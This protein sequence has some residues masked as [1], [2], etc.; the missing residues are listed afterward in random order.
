M[1]ALMH[2]ITPLWASEIEPYPIRVAQFEGQDEYHPVDAQWCRGGGKSTM[3]CCGFDAY[4]QAST[5]SVSKSLTNKATDSD[6]T[7]VVAVESYGF[8]PAERRQVGDLFLEERAK[9]VTNGT[10]PGHHNGV[11]ALLND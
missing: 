10:C 7:P 1:A 9:T 8:D 6:H 4:N 2:G 5:G 3:I 11:L